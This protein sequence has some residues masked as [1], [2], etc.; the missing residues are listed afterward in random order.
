ME[1]FLTSYFG[2]IL[3]AGVLAVFGWAFKSW[4]GSIKQATD[5]IL[6]GLNSLQKEFHQ[7]RVDVERRVTRVE[8]KVDIIHE[9]TRRRELREHED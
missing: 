3:V 7:H 9:D 2:E 5:S 1:S 8:T 6:L 4:S